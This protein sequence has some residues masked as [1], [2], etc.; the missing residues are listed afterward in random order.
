MKKKLVAVYG[1]LR[2][3]LH[4]HGVLG[5]SELLGTFKTE[6]LFSLYS[7]GSYPG[8]KPNGNTSIAM[9]VYSVDDNVASYIDRL[10]GYTKDRPAT[11]YDKVEIETPWGNAG[12][13]LYVPEVYEENLVES[14]DWK[15]FR[16]SKVLESRWCY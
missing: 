9:E 14:G 1:S 11:F 2:K 4:N 6:P 16:Q 12:L 8:L 7:L 15:E 5:N 10:E 13:Y 3:G